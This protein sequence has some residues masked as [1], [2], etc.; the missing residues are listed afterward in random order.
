MVVFV[1]EAAVLFAEREA[2][3]ELLLGLG[4]LLVVAEVDSVDAC[5]LFVTYNT[6]E[7]AD[8]GAADQNVNYR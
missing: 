5:S 7:A 1:V 4:L 6:S 2:L 3:N 8:T